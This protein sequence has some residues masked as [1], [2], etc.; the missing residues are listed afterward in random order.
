MNII[1]TTN[2]IRIKIAHKILDLSSYFYNV[3]GTTFFKQKIIKFF[4]PSFHELIVSP[5]LYGVNL[6]VNVDDYIGKMIYYLLQILHHF[7]VVTM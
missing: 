1:N 5:T 4:I 6:L 2:K 3:R 7:I